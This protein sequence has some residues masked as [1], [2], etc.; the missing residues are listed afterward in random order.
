MFG[1]HVA[2]FIDDSQSWN[3]ECFGELSKFFLV[4]VCDV[5][6]LRVENVRSKSY[7]RLKKRLEPFQTP[8]VQHLVIRVPQILDF[9]QILIIGFKQLK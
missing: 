9:L 4:R 1:L 8:K 5:L 2:D 7:I 6:Q 3:M